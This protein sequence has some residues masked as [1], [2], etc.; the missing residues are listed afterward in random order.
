M[1]VSVNANSAIARGASG[2]R[3]YTKTETFI[4]PVVRKEIT[5]GSLD[6]V[7]PEL[8]DQFAALM[9]TAGNDPSGV[10][11]YETTSER[12]TVTEQDGTTRTY[13]S[14]DELPA[15]VRKNLEPHLKRKPQDQG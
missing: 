9:E 12:I 15:E 4:E 10:V 7:P 8:R 5:Y 13:N 3:R 1:K 14:L 6:E 2:I 11:R